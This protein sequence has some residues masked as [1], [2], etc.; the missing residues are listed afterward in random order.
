MSHPADPELLTDL[1]RRM[2]ARLV[3]D[4]T[5]MA[6]VFA[7]YQ[8]AEG[9]DE[10]GVARR[11]GIEPELVPRVAICNRPRPELFREDVEAIAEHFALAPRPLADLVRDVETLVRF[12]PRPERA[13]G[14][15]LAARTR[16]AEDEDG[17]DRAVAAEAAPPPADQ[18][19]GEGA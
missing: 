10:A 1:A 14:V 11:L 2:A 6:W 16:V 18:P 12:Q 19:E 8:A 5:S 17:Y 9:I 13:A 15:L 4:P 3:D 7:R